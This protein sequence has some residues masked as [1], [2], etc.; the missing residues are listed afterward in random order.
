MKHLLIALCS[1]ILF[2]V[3]FSPPV[4][5]SPVNQIEVKMAIAPVSVYAGIISEMKNAAMVEFVKAPFAVPLARDRSPIGSDQP[6]IFYVSA[7]VTP[8]SGDQKYD[9]AYRQ[10]S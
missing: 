7:Y 6:L 5:A 3:A 1:S 10:R 8:L 2:M 9:R 4:H